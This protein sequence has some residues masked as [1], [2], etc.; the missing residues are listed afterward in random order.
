MYIFPMWSVLQENCCLQIR[1]LCTN[2][3]S[4]KNKVSHKPVIENKLDDI[5]K[6]TSI[7]S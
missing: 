3:A 6:L 5:M 4:N 7:A 2:F 1:K